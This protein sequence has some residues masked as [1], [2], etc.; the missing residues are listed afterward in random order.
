MGFS[1]SLS[2]V[3]AASSQLDTIGNNI[4]NSQTVGFK[5][6]STQFADIYANSQGLGTRVADTVQNFATGSLET[7]G[8]SLD[9]AIAGEGFFQFS[10]NEQMAYSRNGQLT[11]SADGYFENAQGARLTDQQ[12]EPLQITEFSQGAQATTGVESAFN[13]DAESSVPPDAAA[14]D[15]TNSD[16]YNYVTNAGTVY[17]SLGVA[18]DMSMYYT[19]TDTNTWQARASIPNPSGGAP[20]VSGPQTLTFN[21]NGQ[22]DPDPNGDGTNEGVTGFTFTAGDAANG[23]GNG[24]NQLNV[25][26]DLDGTTQN[27]EDFELRE[28]AQD[29]NASGTFVGVDITENGEILANYSNGNSGE[30]GTIGMANFRNPAGLTPEGDNLWTATQESGAA[31]L[32]QAGSGQIGS[33]E[34]GTV[35]ASNVDLTQELVDMII[36]QRNFQANNNAIQTQSDILE[37]VT[38]LR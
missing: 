10:Q 29:G 24:A 20:L 13:L 35:E 31:L 15:Q 12:G 22:L 36:A 37:T 33:L 14:F 23:L 5:S 4:S 6:S 1:Q 25:D 21:G 16:S 3:N 18:H 9:L 30:V 28:F 11:M 8:R 19:K 17:D 34:S 38:N 2:G 27:G 32:G 7:T 26:I